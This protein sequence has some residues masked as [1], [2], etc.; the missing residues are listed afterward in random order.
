MLTGFDN[1][2]NF[3]LRSIKREKIT[4]LRINKLKNLLTII[5]WC[6]IVQCGYSQIFPKEG[7]QL[8]YTELVFDFPPV[9]KA[10]YY[11]LELWDMDDKNPLPYHIQND[12]THVIFCNF[13]AFG[14]SYAWRYSA[15]AGNDVQIYKSMKYEFS[16]LPQA[17]LDSAHFDYLCRGQMGRKGYV[18]L[19]QQR[20]M[21]D[22]KGRVVWRMPKIQ[23]LGVEQPYNVR[24]LR[25]TKEGTF[26]AI[27]TSGIAVEFDR[28]GNILWLA[29]GSQNLKENTGENYHHD[30]RKLNNGNYMVLS[31]SNDKIYLPVNTK[32]TAKYNGMQNVVKDREKY[33]YLGTFGTI[34]EYDAMGKELWKWNSATYFASQLMAGWQ[35]KSTHLNAFYYDEITDKAYLGFRDLNLILEVN[36]K[37]GKVDQEF[38]MPL[39]PGH[40]TTGNGF[41]ALQHSI[42]KTKDGNLLVFNNDSSAIDSVVSSV[43]EFGLKQNREGRVMKKKTSLKIDGSDNGKSEKYGSA[44]YIDDSIVIVG[45]GGTG[46]VLG[47]NIFNNA[48]VFDIIVK[49][50]QSTWAGVLFYRAHYAPSFYPAYF[51]ISR[52]EKGYYLCNE[53]TEDD[54]ISITGMNAKGEKV[55]AE[56]IKIEMGRG[57][58]FNIP[59]KDI[60]YIKAESKQN[61]F[62]IREIEINE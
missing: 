26:T 36:Q 47:I 30:F 7:A 32:D 11:R 56:N 16:I 23:G 8:N 44:E 27:I 29:P 51:S 5:L 37:T 41:F 48:V 28:D 46:R 49:S 50:Y 52:K 38:G 2:S 58:Y 45:A 40:K 62:L 10:S 34:V 42:E 12:S 18:L 3:Y 14:K 35:N 20:S 59:A 17:A 31:E 4:D 61:R 60:R 19:D 21:I 13:F 43:V 55:Y 9:N 24:D 15:Y 1:L 33:Y 39:Y 53:G 25:M 57:I 54:V 6:I 22:F